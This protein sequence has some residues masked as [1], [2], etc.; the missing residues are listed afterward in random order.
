MPDGYR[1][2][3]EDII[4]EAGKQL[5]QSYKETCE[6]IEDDL[7]KRGYTT[8]QRTRKLFWFNVRENMRKT[9]SPNRPGIDELP[10]SEKTKKSISENPALMFSG[11]KQEKMENWIQKALEEN[12]A[13][14][15][16]NQEDIGEQEEYPLDEGTV[17]LLDQ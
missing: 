12:P 1:R 16:L 14:N 5:E 4:D 15:K 13:I 2:S 9:F 7:K 8:Q 10:T 11:E 3:L 17:Y 6:D